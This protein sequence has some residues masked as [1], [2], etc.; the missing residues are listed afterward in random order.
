MSGLVFRLFK[1]AV[2]LIVLVADVGLL[3]P[4]MISC[5]SKE[6]FPQL[7]TMRRLLGI[8]CV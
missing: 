4:S 5:F 7:S 3:S 2:V 6:F 8:F 1:N